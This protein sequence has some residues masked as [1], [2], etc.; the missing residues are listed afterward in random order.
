MKEEKDQQSAPK[1]RD[2]QGEGAAR[3]KAQSGESIQGAC[4][5]AWGSE[6]GKGEVG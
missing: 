5:G 6:A 1:E 2:S 4:A 3:A